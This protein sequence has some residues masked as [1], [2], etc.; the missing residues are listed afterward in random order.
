[1]AY[2]KKIRNE[3]RLG[4]DRQ[5]GNLNYI[6]DLPI[7]TI[8]VVP[9]IGTR[10]SPSITSIIRSIP[11]FKSGADRV[12]ELSNWSVIYEAYASKYGSP[13]RLRTTSNYDYEGTGFS[14][15]GA[16]IGIVIGETVPIVGDVFSDVQSSPELNPGEFTLIMD[17]WV[18][19]NS[20]TGTL[21]W[22][23]EVGNWYGSYSGFYLDDVERGNGSIPGVGGGSA[24]LDA[25]N[26]YP[27]IIPAG[28]I[29]SIVAFA[30]NEVDYAEPPQAFPFSPFN[31]EVKMRNYRLTGNMNIPGK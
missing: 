29:M 8:P 16:G 21:G 26:G 14:T 7:V 1:M 27:L 15:A 6:L 18:G 24:S 3:Y 25:A 4:V 9:A 23:N 11:L 10:P 20:A 30:W 17:S 2:S 31:L 19:I 12:L 13:I 5:Q 28:R 22:R